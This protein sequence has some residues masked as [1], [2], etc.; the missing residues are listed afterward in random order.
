VRRTL[1]CAL[2]LVVLS[3]LAGCGRSGRTI[4]STSALHDLRSAGFTELEIARF[5]KASRNGE[6]DTIGLPDIAMAFLP[7]VQ[8]IDYE[9]DKT[10]IH[11]YGHGPTYVYRWY[12]AD[13]RA[14]EGLVPS[15]FVYSPKKTFSARICNVILWSYNLYDDPRLRGRLSRATRL[16]RQ[17]CGS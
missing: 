12:R 13:V 3:L 7:P 5:T 17:S 10:A 1:A 6:I 14:G 11:F 15:G 9:S 16:L 2:V 8:L 4:S